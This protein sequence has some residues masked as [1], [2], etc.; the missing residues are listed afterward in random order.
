AQTAPATAGD[1]TEAAL[2]RG[3]DAQTHGRL[4]EAEA[5]YRE[6]LEVDDADPRAAQLLGA[7]LVERGR[8]D[9]AL[10]LFERARLRVGP[11]GLG[12]SGFHNNHA[13][14]LRRAGR[15]AEA[16]ALLREVVAVV[17]EE[18]Q[19]WHNLGQVLRDEERYDEAI[20]AL[21]RAVALEPEHGPNHA[22]LGEVLHRI[23]RLRSAEASLRRCIE[24]G[25]DRDINLW[26]L[27]GNNARQLGDLN[28]ALQC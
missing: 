14:A 8:D 12:N 7:I 20:A 28:T 10:D 26:T 5:A 11:P 21:R 27:L 1:A 24:L 9:E 3:L 13:N 19:P 6:L 15:Y 22:V 4:D 23:G 2:R 18:W 17:P 25:W 16:E